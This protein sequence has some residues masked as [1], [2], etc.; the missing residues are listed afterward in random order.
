MGEL[1]AASKVRVMVS[2]WWSRGDGLANHQLG[3]ILTRASGVDQDDLTDPQSLDR[4]LRIAVADPTALAELD[5]WWQ[6]VETRR[7]GNGTRNPGLGLEQSIRYL[8]DRL[9]AATVT[10][11]A[12]DECCR[13]VA[14][15]DQTIISAKDLPELTHPDAE[16]LDLLARYLEARSRVLALA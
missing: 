9:D 14:A 7:A 1:A 8:T 15:V 3:Q 10:P 13:Q 6:M 4:A 12:L 5:G 16:T 2:Y 11:E